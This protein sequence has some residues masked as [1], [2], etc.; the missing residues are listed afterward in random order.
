MTKYAYLWCPFYSVWDFN[1][2]T[3]CFQSLK[4]VKLSSIQLNCVHTR[5][6]LLHCSDQRSQNVHIWQRKSGRDLG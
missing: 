3:F 6:D 4:G 2:F 5:S 1:V